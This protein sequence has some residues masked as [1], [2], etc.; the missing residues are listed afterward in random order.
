MKVLRSSDTDGQFTATQKAA[1]GALA[2]YDS[3][4]RA[5]SA[6]IEEGRVA[7]A[8][9]VKPKADRIKA[10]GLQARGIAEAQMAAIFEETQAS[11]DTAETVQ[12]GLI[13]WCWRWAPASPSSSPA[14]SCAR[15]RA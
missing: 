9:G 4:F 14:A 15:S 13:A 1:E 10:V 11:V 2:A 3:A 12:L 6:A 7:F 8:D 5:A